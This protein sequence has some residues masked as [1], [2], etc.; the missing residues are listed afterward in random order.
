MRNL[1]KLF[2]VACVALCLSACE[3]NYNDKLFWPGEISREYGSYIKPYKLDLTYS[4][5]KLIGKTVSFKT[6]D[7]ETGTLTLNDVIPGEATT[8]ISGIQLIESGEKDAYSFSGTNITMGG[9]TVKYVGSITPKE[10]KLSVDAT[11]AKSPWIR[12]YE[13][14]ELTRG[15]GKI[16]EQDYNSEGWPYIWADT[17]DAMLTSPVYILGEDIELSEKGQSVFTY[18]TMITGVASYFIS[19]LVHTITLSDDGNILADYTTSPLVVD[20]MQFNEIDMS[21]EETMGKIIGFAFKIIGGQLTADDIKAA[22]KNRTWS[23]SS[24]INLAYWYP[25]DGKVYVKINL[26]GIISQVISNSGKSVDPELIAGITEAIAKSDPIKLKNILGT[27][28]SIIN[29]DILGLVVSTDNATFEM[30]FKWIKDGIPFYAEKLIGADQKEH[31]HLYMSNDELTP[32]IMMLPH[33]GELL[34]NAVPNPM[35]ASLVETWLGNDEG[36]IPNTWDGAK[37]HRFGFDLVP[38]MK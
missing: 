15:A 18:N 1:R 25:K 31:T 2:Y 23:N 33:V 7:S 3:E 24:P 16:I 19:Q 27:L 17:D 36:S 9:A 4:G 28:N 37:N 35:L 22:I 30:I 5:E 13:L 20:G 21:N 8:P 11:M 29:N 12:T 10:M 38:V 6:E 26:A 34:I 32:L 14:G